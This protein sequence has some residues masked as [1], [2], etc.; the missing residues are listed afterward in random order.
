MTKT[1]E[2]VI[3]VADLTY[4]Y[5]AHGEFAAVKNLNFHV[6]RGELYAL[7]GT[8]G[9]GKTTTLETIEG[10]RAPTSGRVSVFGG[11]PRDRK[12]VR[13]RVG[14]MLQESGFA[15]DL[16]VA[17]SLRLSGSISGRDDSDDRVLGLVD[18]VSKRDTRVGQ[19]SGGEKRRLDFGMAIWGTPELIFLDEP[20]TGL[21][22][23]ARDGLWD[24][25]AGIRESG[26]TI[27]L[28]T[29]YLEEAQKYA[30]RIGLM[31]QGVLDREG[32]L[33]ELVEGQPSHIEFVAPPGVELPLVAASTLNGLTRVD[34]DNLQRD[35]TALL[36][37]A[38]REGYA[39]DRLSA[40]T[41]SLDDVF[42]SLGRS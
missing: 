2:T 8:N 14:I 41:S 15:G 32:T 29:H 7:L 22:P 37:W 19:L 36:G 16:T 20:T 17:E 30:D 9:A 38:D 10:H 27:I 5:G 39:F 23:S 1:T 26:A 34:T 35:L 40:T 24:V 4:N 28:T 6:R 33:A 31:H 3:E 21:D 25:V 18:L 11:D 42:R 12:T 13:P